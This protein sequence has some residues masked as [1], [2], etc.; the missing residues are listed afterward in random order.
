MHDLAVIIVSHNGA[1]WVR[2][3]LPTVFAHIGEI[4]AEVIVVD[5]HHRHGTATMVENEFPAARVLRTQ[6]HG[7]GHAN[8]C[9]LRTC[10]ARYVLF[11]NP[12][13]EV[14][15]GSFADLLRLL[16]E[17]PTIGLVGCRQVTQSG[18][19][20]VTGRYF[21]NAGRAFGDALAAE[22]LGARRPNW[23]GERELDAARYD[24]EFA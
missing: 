7:F 22:R 8:N 11:L 19:L 2:S 9:A 12:D 16:D 15:R 21:P 6:N 17:R 13:V 23:L 3:L 4:D 5:N 1:G 10:D 18:A 20:T 14:L 24:R